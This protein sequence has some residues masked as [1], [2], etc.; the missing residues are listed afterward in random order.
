LAVFEQMHFDT[1]HIL[2]Q[3]A[4]PKQIYEKFLSYNWMPRYQW[5]FQDAKSRFRFLAYSRGIN[6]EFGLKYLLF[7][8]M[9]IRFLFNNWDT[10]IKIG[11]DQGIENCSGS[12]L[13]MDWWNQILELI[14]ASGYQY[15]LG[16]DIN[17]N[18]IERSHKTDDAEF[19][20]PRA[21]HFKDK[22]SFLEEAAGFHHYF[23]FLRPHSGIC[24]NNNTPFE[25]I[26]QTNFINTEKLMTF[27]I[28][29]LEDH[30]HTI[31]K[32][33]DIL[34]YNSELK[35][36]DCQNPSLKKKIDLAQKYDFSDCWKNFRKR[37]KLSN[38]GFRGFKL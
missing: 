5:T 1:K 3:K 37:L 26:K 18:L 19:Y 27:P 31:R 13:K 2:D 6:S 20:V 14:N 35:H 25:M 9:Y 15:H 28:M 24:M 10:H 34:L 17:K 8:L 29:I 32:T 16:N 11:M 22:K 23:N 38:P 4:L 12:K 33:T 7:C 36:L 21:S 30:I